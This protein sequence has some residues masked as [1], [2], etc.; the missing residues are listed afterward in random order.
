MAKRAFSFLPDMD[1]G[2]D[3]Y[4]RRRAA[5]NSE[6]RRT[7]IKDKIEKRL[8]ASGRPDLMKY[9]EE[10]NFSGER[11]DVPI[12]SSVDK[13]LKSLYENHAS[14]MEKEEA[15]FSKRK[16]KKELRSQIEGLEKD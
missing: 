15:Q 6:S 14:K 12:E 1:R 10:E 3:Y 2:D 8:R 5:G 4:S 7:L 13:G 11:P 9:Y 16:R